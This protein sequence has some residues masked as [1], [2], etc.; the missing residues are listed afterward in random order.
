MKVV[1]L[2]K[3]EALERKI[4]TIRCSDDWGQWH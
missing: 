1:K 3:K 2:C 4:I